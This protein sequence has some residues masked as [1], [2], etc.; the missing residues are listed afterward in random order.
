MCNFNYL[1]KVNKCIFLKIFKGKILF[2]IGVYW[3][4]FFWRSDWVGVVDG[5][6]GRFIVLYIIMAIRIFGVGIKV[7][8][9]FIFI[10]F[11]VVVIG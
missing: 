10:G 7:K 3:I 4:I 5:W 8:L 11:F 6:I 9:I 1:Y 2:I